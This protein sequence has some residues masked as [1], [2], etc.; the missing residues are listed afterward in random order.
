MATFVLIHGAGDS[1]S[2]WRLTGG[3]LRER[4]HDVVAPDL[5]C[6][7][8]SA[9]LAEYTDTVL[10][11]IGDR[12]E[13]VVVAQSAGAF[14]AP[15]VCARTKVEL[16]VLLAAL[17]PAPGEAAKDWWTNTG[18]EPARGDWPNDD[19]SIFYHDVPPELVA[20][21]TKHARTQSDTPSEEPW[22]LDAWPSVS[23]RFLLCRDDRL[24]PADFLRRVAR[25]RLGI[26]PDEI[27][28]GH[29]IALSRPNE[30]AARLDAYRRGQS[31]A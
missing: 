6:D 15:L 29:C 9:G 16:L 3:A 5:P 1:G 17:V 27:D 7:D 25:E 28:G 4:G 21:A 23:T 30:L 8:D 31:A 10:D 20:E 2:Y 14:T 24:L 22:P 26:T 18:Y 19:A 12:T 11:A 13:L